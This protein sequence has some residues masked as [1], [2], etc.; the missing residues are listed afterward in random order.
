[1]TALEQALMQELQQE[2]ALNT[3]II[4]R[5]EKQEQSFISQ[6]QQQQKDYE[7][8]LSKIV[9]NYKASIQQMEKNLTTYLEN[10]KKELESL[11]QEQA[12]LYK[13]QKEMNESLINLPNY[14]N[15]VKEL[16]T[17]LS[18]QGNG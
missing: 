14:E 18:I 9:N 5:L 13:L 11:K 3:E 17:L 10:N 8:N 15:L 16:K 4:E 7:S 1:M 12:L 6:L 2:K